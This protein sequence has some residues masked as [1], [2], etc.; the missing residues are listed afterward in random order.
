MLPGGFDL[1]E[2]SGEE[3]AGI[4]GEK[5]WFRLREPPFF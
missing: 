1:A 4:A 2:L 3:H 5:S